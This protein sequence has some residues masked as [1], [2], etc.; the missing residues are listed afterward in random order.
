MMK[1]DQRKAYSVKKIGDLRA[2]IA[3]SKTI[4]ESK[5]CL[6]VTG[7]FGRNEADATS[8][9]D[10]SIVGLNGRKREHSETND[11]ALSKLDEIIVKADVIDAAKRLEIPKFDGDGKYFIHFSIDEFTKLLGRSDDDVRNTFTARVLLLLE[12]QAILGDDVYREAISS[13]L[14]V[15]FRD[16]ERHKFDFVPGYLANDILRLWR[17]FCVNYE[18][19]LIPDSFESR[20]EAKVRNYTLKHSRLLTC[21][22]ALMYMSAIFEDKK[23][24]G[25]VDALQMVF[26]TPT[27]RLFFLLE[28]QGL[29]DCRDSIMGMLD[30]YEAFLENKALGKKKLIE[31]FS[32]EE[33]RKPFADESN[34]FGKL[35]FDAA[36]RIGKNS[37]LH[38]MLMV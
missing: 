36:Q 4:L 35:V 38:R 10:L 19:R 31:I 21:F 18:A 1:I 28:R 11:S 5:A 25:P 6:Y 13:V 7:S 12:S 27:E 37:R 16:F 23:T 22:S 24:F 8:D 33:R 32:D 15:Y 14:A 26:T 2:Q 20:A 17:T 34:K 9:L 29:E 3:S 30:L